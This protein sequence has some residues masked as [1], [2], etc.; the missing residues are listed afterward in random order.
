MTA[1]SLTG[2]AGFYAYLLTEKGKLFRDHAIIRIPYVGNI[3]RNT[4]TEIFCRVLGIL[5]TSSSENIEAIQI[6]AEAS[7]NA[8]LSHRVKTVV[9]PSMLKYGVE[10]SKALGSANFFPDMV[11]SRYNTAAETGSVKESSVQL[12]DYYQLENQFAMKNLLS[13]IEIMI[14]VVIMVALVF[15]TLLSTETASINIQ[16]S[17]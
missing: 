7:G 9:I 6:A 15:L 16:P 8:Y 12:A 1:V 4:S 2:I 13:F 14:T 10:L 17:V 11:I 5:Y 3:L